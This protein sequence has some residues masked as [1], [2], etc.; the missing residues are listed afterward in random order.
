MILTTSSRPSSIAST[1]DGVAGHQ[2]VAVRAAR[3]PELAVDEHQ[4]GAAD[5]ALAP[6]ERVGA[7]LGVATAA[8]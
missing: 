4:P 7:E 2:R 3:P 1:L 5:D 8:P 6:D